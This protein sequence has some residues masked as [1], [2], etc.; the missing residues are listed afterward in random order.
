MM[1]IMCKLEA[2][3][4]SANSLQHKHLERPSSPAQ[5]DFEHTND[6]QKEDEG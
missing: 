4:L 1:M 5:L 6:E 3:N 2:N